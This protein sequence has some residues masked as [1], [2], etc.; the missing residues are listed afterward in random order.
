MIAPVWGGVRVT[1]GCNMQ[2]PARSLTACLF[3]LLAIPASGGM[4]DGLVAYYP[5]NGNACDVSGNS[6]DASAVTA[7][8]TSDRFGDAN[9]AYLFQGTP[10]R[11][12]ICVP[13]SPALSGPTQITF[14][15]W[16]QNAKGY[17]LKKGVYLQHGTYV[18][19][20][21]G[22]SGAEVYV[23]L[24]GNQE[25][26]AEFTDPIPADTWTHIAGVW[27]GQSI[28]IYL[29]G[30]LKQSTP[31]VGSLQANTSPLY[32]GCDYGTPG[33]TGI[34]GKV[35]DVRIYNRA[36]SANEIKKLY[37]LTKQPQP[38]SPEG[39]QGLTHWHGLRNA[40]LHLLS[41]LLGFPENDSP[42]SGL[43]GYWPFDGSGRDASGHENHAQAFGSPSYGF[44]P[45]IGQYYTHLD[46]SSYFAVPNGDLLDM[47]DTDWT[48]AFWTNPERLLSPSHLTDMWV[49]NSW[50]NHPGGYAI[51]VNYDPDGNTIG[52]SILTHGGVGG[53]VG[54][55]G[56]IVPTGTWSHIAVVHNHETYETSIFMDG[57]LVASQVLAPTLNTV[58]DLHFG[59]GHDY[60]GEPNPNTYFKGKL[61]DMRFYDRQLS[62]NELKLLSKRHEGRQSGKAH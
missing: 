7:T 26:R 51:T 24:S 62:E 58:A 40:L 53:A 18:I 44:D 52:T 42:F 55:G 36:L 60:G 41:R 23:T 21:R 61:G 20:P 57:A 10:V 1:M 3:L 49:D 31:A 34:S 50:A 13:N 5:F 46:G 6:N 14:A 28:R 39:A 47:A 48:I 25:R 30:E 56:G 59:V 15:A 22:A 9:A 17:L 54:G 29:N 4:D 32:I 11:Q 12:Y 16:F 2:S 45:S 19:M 35:D 37:T 8:L 43:I 33:G 27:D 38:P